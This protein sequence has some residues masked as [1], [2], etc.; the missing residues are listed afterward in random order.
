MTTTVTT[1][2]TLTTKQASATPQASQASQTPQASPSTTLKRITYAL[3]PWLVPFVILAAWQAVTA[4]GIV[5]PTIFPTPASVVQAAIDLSATGELWTDILVSTERALAGFVIGGSI[6]FLLGLL[7]GLSRW[8]FRLLDATVQMVRTIPQLSLLPLVIVWFGVS[9]AG[10]VF[11]VALGCLF[12]MYINTL[13][14]IR[15]V[16]HDLIEMG[17][18][19]GLNKRQIIGSIVFP[20]ALPSIL[21]GVR[22]T[23]GIMWLMLIFAETVAADSGIGFLAANAREFMQLNI[24]VLSIIIYALLGKL[25]D[26]IAKFFEHHFLGW[27]FSKEAA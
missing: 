26:S 5:S 4:G 22:Y 6:G 19:Y 13:G 17:R 25:S 16:D 21:I 24:I 12:P 14:G 15:G 18:V 1:A 11:L 23:L 7:N 10:K 8:S 2:T 9:E 27:Y 20:A 3:S